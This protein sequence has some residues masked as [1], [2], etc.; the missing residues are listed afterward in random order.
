MIINI[1]TN[2]VVKI[3]FW[4]QNNFLNLWHW[5]H[6]GWF[7]VKKMVWNVRI[8]AL[9]YTIHIF[10]CIWFVSKKKFVLCEVNF[11][12]QIR[13]LFIFVHNK[14]WKLSLKHSFSLH[15]IHMNL[16]GLVDNF[17]WTLFS[18]KL[19]WNVSIKAFWYTKKGIRSFLE[20]KL[21]K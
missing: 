16:C 9:W 8:K 2:F 3:G 20:K 11:F 21:Y 15:N 18:Q 1:V 10:V 17:K 19:V 7:V 4:L 13:Y 12:K 14:S 5:F 6:K